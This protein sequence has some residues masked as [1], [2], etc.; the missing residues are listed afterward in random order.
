MFGIYRMF[1]TFAEVSIAH[2]FMM[3]SG[4]AVLKILVAIFE[5]AKIQ[6]FI[7]KKI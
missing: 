4:K 2:S 6:N 1:L 3:D 5:K 7:F